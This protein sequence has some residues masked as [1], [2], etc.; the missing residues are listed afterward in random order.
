M[1]A[2]TVP[3]VAAVIRRGPEYLVGCRPH[4]KRHGG[5]WEF[6]GGKV[7]PGESDL[8][9][10]RRELREELGLVLTHLGRTLYTAADPGSPYRVRFVAAWVRGVAVALEHTDLRW[11][12]PAELSDLPLAP[13]DARFVADVLRAAER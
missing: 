8:E 12:T 5:L 7:L 1:S 9:A 11:A 6:P 13:T 10:A 3:V 4:H 2:A